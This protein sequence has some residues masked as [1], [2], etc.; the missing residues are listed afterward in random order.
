MNVILLM[1]LMLV[2]IPIVSEAKWKYELK[3]EG[4]EQRQVSTAICKSENGVNGYKA[5]ITIINVSVIIPINNPEI[6]ASK[7]SELSWKDS[8]YN[9]SE[10]SPLFILPLLDMPFIIS[11]FVKMPLSY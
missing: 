9:P 11:L 10:L 5:Y 4:L 7:N 2:S 3:T 8:L 6:D 1:L